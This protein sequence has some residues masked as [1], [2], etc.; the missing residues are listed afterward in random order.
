MIRAPHFVEREDIDAVTSSFRAGRLPGR[1]TAGAIVLPRRRLRRRREQYRYK[2]I[3]ADFGEREILRR[4][5]SGRTIA[6][7]D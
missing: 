5:C 2:M 4:V 1:T 6:G 7:R 3:S